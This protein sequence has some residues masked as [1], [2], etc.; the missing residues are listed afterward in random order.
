[1][2]IR[3]FR[4]PLCPNSLTPNEWETAIQFLT[5]VGQRCTANRQEF[6]LLSDVLGVSSLVDTLNN[7]AIEKSTAGSVLGPFYTDNAPESMYSSITV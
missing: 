2:T 1:M 6:I 5:R 7:P 4:S 3:T